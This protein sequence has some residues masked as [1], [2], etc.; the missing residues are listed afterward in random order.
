M[1]ASWVHDTSDHFLTTHSAEDLLLAA[2]MDYPS[3]QYDSMNWHLSFIFIPATRFS[4]NCLNSLSTP[5]IQNNAVTES[6]QRYTELMITIHELTALST[7]EAGLEEIDAP[8]SSSLDSLCCFRG[9]TRVLVA[10]NVVDTF[11]SDSSL[12]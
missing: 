6:V 7:A 9:A 5:L 10:T 8:S 1:K 2:Q 4:A 3:L 11:S 12:K